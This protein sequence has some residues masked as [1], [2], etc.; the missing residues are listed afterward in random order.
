MERS[1]NFSLQYE[2]STDSSKT[3]NMIPQELFPPPLRN[4]PVEEQ[5]RYLL[6]R[7][8]TIERLLRSLETYSREREGTLPKGQSSGAAVVHGVG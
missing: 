5:L 1:T 4:A 3:G 7:R 2:N 8:A 6:E